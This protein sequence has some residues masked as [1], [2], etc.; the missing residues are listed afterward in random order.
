MLNLALTVSQEWCALGSEEQGLAPT[1]WLFVAPHNERHDPAHLVTHRVCM[2]PVAL[3]QAVVNYLPQHDQHQ[4]QQQQHHQPP[5]HHHHHHHHQQQQRLRQRQ[6]SEYACLLQQL[7][8]VAGTQ[9]NASLAEIQEL[10]EPHVARQL[11][12][13]LP[14]GNGMFL[15]NSMPIRDM[16]MFGGRQRAT[17]AA[18]AAAAAAGG[19]AGGGDGP[20]GAR[21]SDTTAAGNGPSAAVT[22]V[23]DAGGYEELSGPSG[24]ILGH[25]PLASSIGS[26]AT[27]GKSLH[28]A[29]GAG[30]GFSA[31]R[32][33]AGK[34]G[35]PIGANRGASGIDGVLSTAAGFAEGLA[36]P[37]TLV[38]GDLS[39]LHDVNGLG[40]LRGGEMRPPLTVV[41]VNNAGGGI[42]SFLPVAGSVPQEVFTQLWA[43]PQNADLEGGC[44]ETVM[45]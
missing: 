45:A 27:G 41:L 8:D 37:V 31:A 14:P 34:L 6:P 43:T 32:G 20:S 15:G 19:T 11:A 5:H 16:D 10:S 7:D 40:L 23:D 29:S 38:V 25:L 24:S 39:F 21:G 42:F 22:S 33:A 12:M 1:P 3:A 18:A 26:S 35:A 28:A 13:A 2:S 4:Q 30:S 9:I 36:R 44:R 17:A